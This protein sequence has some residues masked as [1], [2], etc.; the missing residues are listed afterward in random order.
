MPDTR[1]FGD[2]MRLKMNDL[3]L[4]RWNHWRCSV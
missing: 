3:L 2:A 4:G 1:G